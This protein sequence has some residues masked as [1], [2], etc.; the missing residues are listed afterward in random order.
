MA[1]V[2]K[3]LAGYPDPST[4][5]Q[6]DVLARGGVIRQISGIADIANGDSANSI[7][8][9]GKVPSS[10]KPAPGGVVTHPGITGL[11]DVDLGFTADPDAL[12][13]GLNL[14]SAGTKSPT[15]AV[16]IAN[17]DKTFWQLAGLSSN[18]GGEL[19]VFMT[20]KA[21]AGAAGAV[22]I[23]LPYVAKN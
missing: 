7:F 23:F 17:M 12:A 6:P 2:T 9:I 4:F 20:L 15:A 22:H 13:D 10:A 18:P 11:T 19:D 3:Y 1:V 16:A 21:A 14:S 8:Y 5:A